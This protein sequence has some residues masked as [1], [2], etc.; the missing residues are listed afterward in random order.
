MNRR[1]DIDWLRVIAIVLVLYFHTAMIFVEEWDWHIKNEEKSYLWLEFNFFLSSF[2][3]P[4]LFFISGVG[5]YFALKRRTGWQYIK[6]RHNR[7]L[8]PVIFGMFVIVPPQI[9]FERIFNG[10]SFSSYFDF[11]P[12]VLQ[13]IPYPN[14][15][16]SWHHLWFVVYLFV[17]S[18]VA[19]PVF[20][21]LKSA[22]GK[23]LLNGFTWLSSKWGLYVLLIP[24][25]L[26]FATLCRWYPRSND[27]IHDLGY[28][29]YWFTFFFSGYLVESDARVWERIEKNRK[30]SLM[31]AFLVLVVMNVIRWNRIEPHLLEESAFQMYYAVVFRAL[32][33]ICGWLW[34]LVALGYGRKYLNQP[35]RFLA[36][37]NRGIY[38]FYILHQT[39]IIM[40]G[41][42][43]I[44][45]SESIL[46]KFLFISTLSLILS[47]VI[48]D[49]LIR[50]FRI[51][52][53]LFGVKEERPKTGR[54]GS[55][56]Q[57]NY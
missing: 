6:E 38:P 35:S 21:Y 36:Y 40:I 9:Y 19:A 43:V 46:S 13:L 30:L 28:L 50:P 26:C 23:K 20:V 10:Q 52:R 49:F 18:A 12:S 17:F 57:R 42:Y 51:T 25:V 8:I 2:R 4:L 45:V 37:A 3:M 41:Y 11:Y 55:D 44:Q 22:S 15:N 5:S 33:P 24:T 16:F 32:Y 39:I 14:G 56:T 34:L 54:D 1:Y 27:L 47:V 31:M 7:L 53:F 48:Y 29:V